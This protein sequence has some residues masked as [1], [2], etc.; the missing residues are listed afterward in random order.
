M[1][2][3][4]HTTRY[5]P[6]QRATTP[7]TTT[8]AQLD[9]GAA[10]LCLCMCIS[11]VRLPFANGIQI[12]RCSTRAQGRHLV[13]EGAREKLAAPIRR[14]SIARACRCVH[15]CTRYR[16]QVCGCA[17]AAEIAHCSPPLA[18]ARTLCDALSRSLTLSR[19]CVIVYKGFLTFFLSL[20]LLNQTNAQLTK[21]RQ[22]TMVTKWLFTTMFTRRLYR[23]TAY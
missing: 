17:Y 1:N 9:E 10:R 18:T 4:Y 21:I 12:R 6:A 23:R 22:Q 7:A 3:H 19:S 13:W 14:R 15:V 20:S 16:V 2:N 11:A 8:T 5:N